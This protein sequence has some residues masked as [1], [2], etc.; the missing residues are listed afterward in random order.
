MAVNQ[1]RKVA[2]PSRINY[3][4]HLTSAQ[5][6]PMRRTPLKMLLPMGDL[7]IDIHAF[8]RNHQFKSMNITEHAAKVL[9]DAINKCRNRDFGVVCN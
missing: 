5:C 3:T 7:E 8:T 1:L 9:S 6:I 4:P 2:R